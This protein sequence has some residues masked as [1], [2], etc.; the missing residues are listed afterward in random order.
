MLCHLDCTVSPN[1]SPVITHSTTAQQTPDNCIAQ[2]QI[3]KA[4]HGMTTPWFGG[5][6]SNCPF[7]P[8]STT[9]ST[10]NT[11]SPMQAYRF[12][13]L[14]KETNQHYPGLTL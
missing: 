14:T 1:F 4:S 5:M 12:P 2:T 10:L 6:V 3:T 9:S 13:D 7:P 8:E 11:L